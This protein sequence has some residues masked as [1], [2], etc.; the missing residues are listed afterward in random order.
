[1][2]LGPAQPVQ[3]TLPVS[4]RLNNFNLIRLFAALQVLIGHG[5]SHLK[6]QPPD[7][8]WVILNYFSGVPIFFVISGFLISMSWDRAPS[9]RQYIWNRILRI[10]PALWICLFFSI[11]IFLSSGVR[12]DSL[13]NFLKWFIAQVTFFQFY[14]P[15]F[16]RGFG[17]G[18]LNGSL[19]TIPIELQFYIL[20]PLLAM[21]AK[22]R[23]GVWVAY[24]LMAAAL[25]I[26]SAPYL[27]ERTTIVQKLLGVSIIP[28]FFFFLIGVTARHLYEECP[29]LFEGKGFIWGGVY[30]LWVS[31]EVIFKIEGRSGNQ[32]N[33]LSIIL[34]GALTVSLAFSRSQISSSILKDNDI[35][36]GVYIYHVPIINLLVFYQMIGAPGFIVMLIVTI[37]AAMLS[38]RF[39]ERP[40]LRL[41]SY[42]L[43]PGGTHQ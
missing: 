19:W 38:W 6:V 10:Y 24:T 15:D 20:L 23:R 37:C 34:L 14:N 29:R 28:Y 31:V 40:A 7:F 13:P 33:I 21:A 8:V 12:P 32:L 35:S 16:L 36:Y 1:M 42:S 11:G 27:V 18:V 4:V 17:I 30:V 39:I 2:T 5:V 22:G 41:K 3:R 26:L 9:L 43:L 25:L